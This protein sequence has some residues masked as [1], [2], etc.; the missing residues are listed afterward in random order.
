MK[1]WMTH[2]KG[3]KLKVFLPYPSH[4]C[5][6]KEPLCSTC[7]CCDL[8]RCLVPRHLAS[9]RSFW[10]LLAAWKCPGTSP[11]PCCS[12]WDLLLWILISN[13][14]FN[15]SVTCCSHIGGTRCMFYLVSLLTTV[16]WR[17]AEAL[18]R[19]W[20]VLYFRAS[21]NT[22]PKGKCFPL[23]VKNSRGF[24]HHLPWSFPDP[25]SW[26]W[27]WIVCLAEKSYSSFLTAEMWWL[28][29][30]SPCGINVP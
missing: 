12:S 22:Q 24:F 27:V 16:G 25:W 10:R 5:P 26:G 30:W 29:Q 2:A 21:L 19:I 4:E 14:N 18:E 1:D 13:R 20:E 23:S 7:G 6:A 11:C 8:Q 9:N 28:H 3:I 17:A 15:R